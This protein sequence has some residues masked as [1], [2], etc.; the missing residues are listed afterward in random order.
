MPYHAP[1]YLTM[2][3]ALAQMKSFDESISAYQR[4]IQFYPAYAVVAHN[5][6]GVIQLHQ[7]RFDRA[8][9]SFQ[10][11]IDLDTGNV[12]S[13]DLLYNL[14]YAL[15]KLGK[16]AEAQRAAEAKRAAK[17]QRALEGTIQSPRE[18]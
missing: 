13:A 2:A 11:A 17:M 14:S 7:G 10:K 12:W 4:A 3:Y 18:R 6:I 15:K 5:A 9:A 8:A 16:D 1:A